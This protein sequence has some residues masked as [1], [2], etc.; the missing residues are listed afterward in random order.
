MNGKSPNPAEDP[1][2]A[3]F[4][5]TP[6]PDIDWVARLVIVYSEML[7]KLFQDGEGHGTKPVGTLAMAMTQGIPFLVVAV[8]DRDEKGEFLFYKHANK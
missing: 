4:N 2:R 1:L 8:V 7:K 3:W 5:N 6:L